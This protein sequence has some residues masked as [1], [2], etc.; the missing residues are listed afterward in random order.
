MPGHVPGTLLP[1][2]R[3]SAPPLPWPCA[4]SARSAA[5]ANG[6]PP[7]TAR[8]TGSGA[9]VSKPSGEATGPGR[10]LGRPGPP[11]IVADGDL[12]DLVEGLDPDRPAA[13]QLRAR[14]GVSVPTAYK[15]LSRARRLGLIEQR[16]RNLYPARSH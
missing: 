11:P 10:E 13:G 4:T 5:S 16:G 7:T 12:A 6:T 3:E 9:A 2:D 14:L 1:D 8:S 15:V